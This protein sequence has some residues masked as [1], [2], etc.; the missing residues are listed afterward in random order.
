MKS[1]HIHPLI[2]V[3][4]LLSIAALSSL[5]SA[6]VFP[7]V[8]PE[9]VFA[10]KANAADAVV[11]FNYDGSYHHIQGGTADP[12]M[13]RGFFTWD[14]ET[15][16]F[17]NQSYIDTSGTAG[18]SFPAAGPSNTSLIA[19]SG[20]TLTYTPNGNAPLVFTRVVNTTNA[21][22]GSW[23]IP[24][25]R[26]TVT[27]L[28]DGSYYLADEA[29]DAPFGYTGMEKGS[30]T[31]NSSSKAFTAT[32]NID[33]NGDVGF[34][35][36]PGA[37]VNITGNSLVFA[38][39]GESTTLARI[40]TSASPLDQP[41]FGIVRYANYVQTSNAAPTSAPYNLGIE[42][43]P[44]FLEAFVGSAIGAT[45][46]TLKIGM[47]TPVVIDAE[48]GGKFEIEEPFA[49]VSALNSFS[50]A[51]S[52]VLFKDGTAEANLTTSA[53]LT[54]P[55]I[56]KIILRAGDAW[57][58]GVYRFG[59]SEVLQWTLPAGF[60]PSQYLTN[61][62]VHDLVDDQT[63]VN[64]VLQGEVTHF[65][66][67]NK[68]QPG[69]QYEI[70]LEFFRI[71]STTTTGNGIFSGKLGY[72]LS[73]SSTSF[74]VAALPAGEVPIITELPTSQVGTPNTP[75]T[76]S[77]GIN[78]AAFPTADF[79]WLRNG[80][81]IPGQSANSLYIPNFDFDVH[82]GR[83]TIIATNP[84]GS[85]ESESFSLGK[86]GTASRHVQRLILSKRRISEQQSA[87]LLTEIGA[88]FDARVEGLDLTNSF[89]STGVR[90]EKLLGAT[91]PLAF[92]GDHWDAETDFSS[93]TAMQTA[94]PNGSY[95]FHVGAETVLMTMIGNNYP[96]EPLVT[97]S[98]GT[99]VNGK[100]QVTAAQA[101][102]GFTL[103]TNATTGDGVA[104][105]KITDSNDDEIL[106]AQ[107]N[108]TPSAPDFV[109]ATL[110]PNQLSLGQ[111]YEV[112]THFDQVR[113][114][115]SLTNRTWG[116][117]T[118]GNAQALTLQ[119]TTSVMKIEVVPDAVGNPYADWAAGFFN[120]TQLANPAI[121]GPGA[122]FEND[123]I[124]NLL[125]YLLGGNPIL[126]SSNLLPTITKAPGSANLVFTY[127]RK[128]AAT[129]VTQVI[130]H[131]PNLAPPWTPAVHGTGGVTIVTSPVD[132]QTEQVTV[133]IPS[134]SASRFV[135][136]KANQ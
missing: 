114:F 107:A 54:F 109:T 46:P 10:W 6:Q 8:A 115:N 125:E 117:P 101:A 81:P 27:F 62:D 95:N 112:E 31:W 119:S 14:K 121:S 102:A 91:T 61:L 72:V 41:D 136:L 130:E 70:E 99:W 118:E 56:P 67:Q 12:A 108:T 135:R 23:K 87:T 42:S 105:L 4:I 32:P 104:T 50:P 120:P 18:F 86:V 75:L 5:V 17:T 134:A 116:P 110:A 33:T 59:Q 3:A 34:S 127:K 11:V 128:L 90:I 26:F 73:A 100:L 16:V 89:P 2:R 57:S 69:R 71:D 21:I 43:A 113:E 98:I 49:S 97:S 106:S 79:R 131:S 44:H 48:D 40:V 76:L 94:F 19:I 93:F 74:K 129:G 66:L 22:V 29:N 111:T 25:E 30:Y 36:V 123:G 68:L 51:A 9:I 63:L 28:A 7:E 35:N 24:G 85:I 1:S 38:A 132:A 58:G 45:A 53:S 13:E 92:D 126:P 52:T 37:T 84:L 82:S 96:N 65:D 80:E 64:T 78:T 55:S 60:N 15:Q 103:T 47:G 124:P 133:T 77:V 39:S 88:A 122:D 20:D 83:Y